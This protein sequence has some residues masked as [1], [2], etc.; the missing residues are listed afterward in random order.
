MKYVYDNAFLTGCDESTEWMLPWFIGHFRTHHSTPLV[1][2][3]FGVSPKARA[4]MQQQSNCII[5]MTQTVEKGWFKKPKAML[6]SPS[7]NTVWIDTDCQVM[8]NC[9][10]IF[11]KIVPNKLLMAEDK[12]WSRRREEKWHNSGIVGFH[13][14]PRILTLW[15]QEV[16]TNP[17]VGD[18][19]V[20][21]SMLNPITKMTYIEDLDNR[22]N[23]LR[24]QVEMDGHMGAT[25]IIHWTGPKG[26]LRIQR[27]ING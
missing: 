12:P 10:K 1:F 5:D 7:L 22:Y 26:K 13:K 21:H 2:A 18:Q 17:E 4:F 9:D 15:A 8:N 20:L 14:K 27:M 6:A 23:V 3:D 19:E 24:I 25:D 11:D 16:Q